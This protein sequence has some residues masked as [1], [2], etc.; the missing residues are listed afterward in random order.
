MLLI[1]APTQVFERL[2]PRERQIASLICQA[3]QNKEIADTLGIS[4]NTVRKQTTR[5]YEKL[6]V[7]GRVALVALVARWGNAD[8]GGEAR[9][10][11]GA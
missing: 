3:L 2:S 11:Q 9:R 6:R 7:S 8:F 4:V 1:P 5:I 10:V